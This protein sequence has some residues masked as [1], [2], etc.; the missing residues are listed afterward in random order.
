MSE[1]ASSF[2]RVLANRDIYDMDNDTMTLLFDP[3]M[4]RLRGSEYFIHF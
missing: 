2:C 1:N 3:R 4:T